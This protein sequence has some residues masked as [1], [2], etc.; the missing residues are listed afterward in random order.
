[1]KDAVGGKASTTVSGL[2]E[3]GARSQGK[4]AGD[5]RRHG[6]GGPQCTPEEVELYLRVI[7][8]MLR[9]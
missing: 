4:A 6:R 2:G 9:N 3:S 8:H 1:M 5:V 7:V